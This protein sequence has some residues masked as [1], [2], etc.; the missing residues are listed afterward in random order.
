[1]PEPL[2]DDDTRLMEAV[3]GGDDTAFAV[4]VER[5][6][7]SAW[8]LAVRLTQDES[9]AED[10]LQDAFLRVL[11]A[12]P[13]YR[14][15]AAFGTWLHRIVVNLAIDRSRRRSVRRSVGLGSDTALLAG[16]APTATAPEDLARVERAEH[17]QRA[18]AALPP[19]YRAAVVLRY[20]EGR[21]AR[22]TGAVLGRSPKAVERLLARA[23]AKLAPLLRHLVE[24]PPSSRGMPD[25]NA[26]K[27]P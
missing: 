5:H 2:S 1:M 19:D 14:P 23:R 4:L 21:D 20:I 9:A 22:D 16:A 15:T 10:L 8:R 13:R 11:R 26:L 7:P 6:T 25:D 18:L 24:D 3:A 17:I 27:G 12:A